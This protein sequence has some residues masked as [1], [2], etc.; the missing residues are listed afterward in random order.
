MVILITI[1]FPILSRL[2]SA[3]HKKHAKHSTAVSNS[4]RT[5]GQPD[6]TETEQKNGDVECT[7]SSQH[8]SEAR[9]NYSCISFLSLLE[10]LSQT[11][12]SSFRGKHLWVSENWDT[13][14][15]WVS[16][17]LSHVNRAFPFVFASSSG[18]PAVHLCFSFFPHCCDKTPRH[19]QLQG[20][21]VNSG[22]QF[23]EAVN[24]SGEVKAA[25]AG[26]S[27]HTA[28]ATRTQR[29]STKRLCSVHFLLCLQSRT[30]HS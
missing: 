2:T 13:A 10:I 7:R 22:S 17:L 9:L 12:S 24:H 25:G 28:P 16:P 4:K 21:R 18:P 6:C 23:Q 20:K 15:S 8:K 11:P 5:T 27:C 19:K 14:L 26:S 30:P 3:K 1:C 29:A